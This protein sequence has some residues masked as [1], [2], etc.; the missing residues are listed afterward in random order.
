MVSIGRRF[1]GSFSEKTSPFANTSMARQLG[2]IVGKRDTENPDRVLFSG[3]EVIKGV[4]E[5]S[6]LAM[7]GVSSKISKSFSHFRGKEF[8][9]K[10]NYE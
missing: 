9:N 8:N 4:I 3:P 6:T 2:M 7:G 10:C 1:T 5:T